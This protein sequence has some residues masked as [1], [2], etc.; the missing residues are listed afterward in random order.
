M[1]D[2]Y[3]AIVVGY[4]ANWLALKVHMPPIMKFLQK[5]VD[6][7]KRPHVVNGLYIVSIT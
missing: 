1:K 4:L 7:A 6:I 2:V 3:L 5:V